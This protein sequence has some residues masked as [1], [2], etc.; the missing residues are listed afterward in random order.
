VRDFRVSLIV[1][2][3][4][5]LGLRSTSSAD[6]G[7]S[8]SPNDVFRSVQ[9]IVTADWHPRAADASH[10]RY[11]SVDINPWSPPRQSHSSVMAGRE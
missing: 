2:L 8:P 11:R 5:L 3:S 4:L 6:G 1:V 7:T 9:R 10:W